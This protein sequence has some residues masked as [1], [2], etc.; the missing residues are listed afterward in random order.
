MAETEDSHPHLELAR[1]E[2]VT[3]R[4]PRGGGVARERPPGF[5]QHAAALRQRLESVRQAT[6]DE[7]SGYDAR[8]LFKIELTD[9]VAPAD[10]AR[11]IKGIEIV[12]QEGGK[13]VLAF[14]T[15]RQL[16]LFESRLKDLADGETVT[17]QNVMYALHDLGSWTPEDRKGWALKQAGF[18]DDSSFLL[19]VELWP[20][21][22]NMDTARAAFE[23]WLSENGGEQLD[24]LRRPYLTLYRV[25]CS[26][27]VADRLLNHRDVRTVDLPPRLGLEQ[28]L[29]LADMEEFGDVPAPPD[30]APGIVVMDSGLAAGHPMLAPAVGDAQTY[31]DGTTAADE[32]GHGT[33]VAGIALYDDVAACV[34]DRRFVPALRLFSAR[35][36]DDKNEGQPRLIHNQV[37]SAVR[38][39]VEQYD[40][41]IFNLSYG[42]LNKPYDKRHLR[43][44]AVT[45][46]ALSRDLNV[47]FVVP[48]GNFEGDR[49]GPSDW[50]TEYPTYL[51]S[52][53]A[54]LLDPA[55]A[56]NV[57]TVGSLV[58]YD[59]SHQSTRHPHDPSYQPVARVDQP[60]PFT[61]AGPSLNG[62]IKPDLVDYGGNWGIDI[63]GG[64]AAMTKVGEL[65]TSRDFA[66]GRPFAQDSGTSFA[67]PH[68]AHAAA[69]VL[70]ELPN[71]SPD[72]CRALLVAHASP[73]RAC[74]DLF[75]DDGD[76]LRDLAGYGLVDRSALYRSLEDCVTLWAEGA[77]QNRKHH[78]YELPIPAE[79]WEGG[80][81]NRHLTVALAYRPPVRTTRIDYRAVGI[82]FNLV[83]AASLHEAAQAFNAAMDRET[84]PSIKEP[85]TN[86]E[87]TA[88]LRSNGTVQ[89]ST[90]TIKQPSRSARDNSWFVVVTRNDPPWGET[91]AA[92]QEPYAL[93]VR[94][95]DRL[96]V[97]PRL[98][99]RLAAR[100]RARARARATA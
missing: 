45:L 13:L 9:K 96:A 66:A 7:A 23:D 49:R 4:R 61:R 65:S 39:F 38:Y 80:R 53:R 68:V 85:S 63:R 83:K 17:Y 76:R 81:R 99:T 42:D 84:H 30:K 92:E 19:D 1:E 55:P 37:E 24:A 12:S 43:G 93:A 8:L 62:A 14:A 36:L 57:L 5:E 25:R 90:W 41:R 31:L 29:L 21:E 75:A 87:I 11:A 20:L 88:Q 22:R 78:F 15:E 100:L 94:L 52:E 6:D 28:S 34:Q 47:L 59:Q 35:V 27:A 77:I 72:L 86:R 16:N 48:T 3:E 67:A 50:R 2:P 18:P 74:R 91:L 44:L 58:R 46:D 51:N 73:T 40:C 69:Q 95:E 26:P 32:H 33:I 56:L 71:A 89:A 98:Y 82:T 10:L 79:F 54:P 70:T 60:S 64:A 97:Q